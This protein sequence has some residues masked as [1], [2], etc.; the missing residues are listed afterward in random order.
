MKRFHF[1]VAA[2]IAV[3]SAFQIFSAAAQTSNTDPAEVSEGLNAIFNL[4][5]TGEQTRNRLNANT[6][7]VMTG[8]IGGTYVQFGADLAS[9]LDD[10]DKLRVL[11]IIGRGS[12]QSLADI[13]YLKGVDVGVMRSDT[14]DYLERKGYTKNVKKDLTYITKLYN[15]EMHVVAAKSVKKL[16]DLNGKTVSVDLPNGG[17]F[18]TAMTVFERLGIKPNYVFIEQR[19]AYEKLRKG[20]IDAM[21]A[22]QGKPSKF[23]TQISDPNLHLVPVEYPASLQADYLPSQLSAKDYPCLL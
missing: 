20:E 12:V 8:T 11:P 17:T 23:V 19:L 5:S 9:A 16:A 4:G 7:T 21:V 18:V 2:A 6:V 13:I 14:L 3:G 1:A 15:E 22:V 10:G